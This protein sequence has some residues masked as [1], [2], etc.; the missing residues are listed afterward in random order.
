VV[1][2]RVIPPVAT[3]LRNRSR[4]AH[5]LHLLRLLEQV[6]VHALGCVPGDVAVHRPHTG[7]VELDLYNEVAL[8]PDELDIATLRVAGVD[9]G[10]VPLSD[11]FVEDEKIVTMDV[12][13]VGRWEADAS[14]DYADGFGVSH[15][16]DTFRLGGGQH[17][18]EFWTQLHSRTLVKLVFPTAASR[19][20]GSLKSPT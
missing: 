1:A 9:D 20:T 18:H 11:S 8:G 7:V 14:H 16:E 4:H 5:F 13:R 19:K 6:D 17:E 12:E 15:V 10:A 3:C 2:V